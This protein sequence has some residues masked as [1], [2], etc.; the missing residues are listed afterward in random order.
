MEAAGFVLK[1]GA[2][3]VEATA[4]HPVLSG[5]ATARIEASPLSSIVVTDTIPLSPEKRIDK[6]EIC[7]VSQLFA[8]AILAIHDGSSISSLFR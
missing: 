3:S 8:D 1:H 5:G 7:S 2:V 4:V 6:I